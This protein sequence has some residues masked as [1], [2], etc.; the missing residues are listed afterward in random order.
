MSHRPIEP[1]RPHRKPSSYLV[2]GSWSAVDLFKANLS[3]YLR[4]SR[5]RFDTVALH[6]VVCDDDHCMTA[7]AKSSP[8]LTQRR[9]EVAEE[10]G[11]LRQASIAANWLWNKAYQIRTLVEPC[12]ATFLSDMPE[13]DVILAAR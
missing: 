1:K 5:V 11:K 10:A 9:V 3:R 7:W 6:C 8:H 13:T 12:V 4:E 2:N